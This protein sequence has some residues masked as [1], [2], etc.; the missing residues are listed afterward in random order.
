MRLSLAATRR[1]LDVD[2]SFSFFSLLLFSFPSLPPSLS[3]S[4]TLSRACSFSSF[5]DLRA[6]SF[7]ACVIVLSFSLSTAMSFLFRFVV[8]VRRYIK[9]IGSGFAAQYASTYLGSELQLREENAKQ[10]ERAK[11]EG[12]DVRRVG[13]FFSSFLFFSVSFFFLSRPPSLSSRHQEK[14]SRGGTR[15]RS[16]FARSSPDSPGPGGLRRGRSLFLACFFHYIAFIFISLNKRL[17][18]TVT[19]PLFH[20]FLFVGSQSS[21]PLIG[22]VS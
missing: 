8:L 18:T 2:F 3:L 14:I 5:A 10:V 1:L 7:R 19:S 17:V 11:K 16:P 6:R 20:S 13:A 4:R 21:W 9:H 22:L 12:R 15:Y